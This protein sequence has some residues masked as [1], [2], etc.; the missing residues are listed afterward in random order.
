MEKEP[1]KA[2]CLLALGRTIMKSL[3]IVIMSCLSLGIAACA[4]KSTALKAE[5]SLI[6]QSESKEIQRLADGRNEQ[7]RVI[8]VEIACPGRFPGPIRLAVEVKNT[9]GQILADVMPSFGITDRE[10]SRK[11]YL[12]IRETDI[13]RHPC[14]VLSAIITSEG[15]DPIFIQHQFENE[16]EA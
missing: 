10:R 7:R 14:A 8:L 9:E 11:V 16:K 15:F 2:P 3:I 1:D 6:G 12:F 5:W 4:R 13:E